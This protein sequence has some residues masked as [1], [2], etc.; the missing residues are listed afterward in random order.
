MPKQTIKIGRNNN[1]TIIIE[2]GKIS[3]EHAEIIK[4][5]EN[6]FLIKDLDT[7]HGTFVNGKRIKQTKLTEESKLQLSDFELDAKLILSKLNSDD[8]NKQI[9]YTDLLKH[10]EI[11]EEFLKLE[12][13]Y[14]QYKKDK[15]KIERGGGLKKTGLRAGLALI[16]FVGNAIGIMAGGALDSRKALDE[17]NEKFKKEYVCPKCYKHFGQE[18]FDNIEKRGY[19]F[20]CKTKWN[21]D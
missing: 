1:N 15:R 11:T 12:N 9:K 21:T 3:R 19:C 14:E 17:L 2:L 4:F 5:S 6:E 18:P 13:I 20:Y 8:F 10:K 16:P 7:A